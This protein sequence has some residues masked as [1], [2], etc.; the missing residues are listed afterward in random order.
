MIFE[1]LMMP[2]LLSLL[3]A[4]LSLTFGLF[5]IAVAL[6]RPEFAWNKWGAGLSFLTAVYAVAVFFQYTLAEAPANILCCSTMP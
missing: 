1:S 2:M 6:K 4:P 5:Q 3:V